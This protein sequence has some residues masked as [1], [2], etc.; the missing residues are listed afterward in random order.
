MTEAREDGAESRSDVQE[1]VNVGVGVIPSSACVEF[2]V[3]D[4]PAGCFQGV[5]LHLCPLALQVAHPHRL[6]I[7]PT[8]IFRP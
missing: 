2:C 3:L 8:A 4:I 5:N 6:L 7:F 1:S